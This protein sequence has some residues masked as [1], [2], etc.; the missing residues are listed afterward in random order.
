MQK[1]KE[2]EVNIPANLEEV[3]CLSSFPFD[4]NPFLV[5]IRVKQLFFC[6]HKELH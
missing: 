3:L 1:E 4:T 5:S 6:C 2:A